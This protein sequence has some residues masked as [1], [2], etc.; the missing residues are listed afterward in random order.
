[1]KAISDDDSG[2]RVRQ[3]FMKIKDKHKAVYTATL[4][5]G[6][7][8][9][10]VMSLVGTV[11]AVRKTESKCVTGPSDRPTDTVSYRSRQKTRRR[12]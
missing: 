6:S 9:G 12:R 11:K 1:M 4:I 5:A 8:T 3:R 2:M 7:W 10:A